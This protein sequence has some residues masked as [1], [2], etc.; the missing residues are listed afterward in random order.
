MKIFKI[1]FIFFVCSFFIIDVASSLMI[2]RNID[3][4]K[5][6]TIFVVIDNVNLK[7]EAPLDDHMDNLTI[8]QE[9]YE[10][11][12]LDVGF[13]VI[14]RSKI[15]A[16]LEEQKLSASGVVTEEEAY[17]IGKIVAADAVLFVNVR[18][19]GSETWEAVRLIKVD[20]GEIALFANIKYIAKEKYK[21]GNHPK[22]L[23]IK[24][25]RDYLDS[26]RKG[27]TK[28]K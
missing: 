19:M 9:F 5:I 21:K 20:T 2:N 7:D 6:R 28:S 14:T 25:F 3:H 26:I 1:T 24:L 15:N 23:R 4:S 17:R 13:N 18:L 16:L 27:K 12:L 8:W 10:G 11:Y 22:D